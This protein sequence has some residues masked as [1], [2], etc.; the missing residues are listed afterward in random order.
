M[1]SKEEIENVAILA[2]IT[3][4]NAEIV[5]LQKEI[6]SILAY[7]GQI[8]AVVSNE[9]G[10][11]PQIPLNHNVMREDV[12]REIATTMEGK[13]DSILAQFP[14]RE[15]DFAVARKIIHKDI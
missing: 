11:M 4:T 2:R 6:P 7:V 15:G 8:S 9:H 3:L 12:P 10:A 14:R 13:R 1:I 5:A